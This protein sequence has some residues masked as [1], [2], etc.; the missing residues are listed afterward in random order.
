M[1]FLP[2][3]YSTH[4]E[5]SLR[6][7]VGGHFSSSTITLQVKLLDRKLG[8]LYISCIA[9]AIGY[10]VGVRV[11][12]ER[13][14]DAHEKAYGIVGATLTGTVCT[15]HRGVVVPYDAAS[16]SQREENDSSFLPTRMLSTLGQRLGN[17]TAPEEP[18]E[19]DTD[20]DREAPLA[21]GLCNHG[22]CTRHTWCNAGRGT[23]Q[24]ANPFAGATLDEEKLVDLIALRLCVASTV[25]PP[26][27]PAV[28]CLPYSTAPS[29]PRSV[30]MSTIQFPTLGCKRASRRPAPPT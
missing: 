26:H 3:A 11:L 21:D 13:G 25:T 4:K 17:C 29:F 6:A 1:V 20:C 22:H 8:I 23:S 2:T 24:V 27:R 7:H 16:L 5:V 30:L 19:E 15:L 14:Y 10:V 18:C 12:L 28:V 9:L